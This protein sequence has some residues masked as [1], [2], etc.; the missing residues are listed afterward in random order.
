MARHCHSACRANKQ[1]CNAPAGRGGEGRVSAALPLE[2]P[3]PPRE[4]L[5]VTVVGLYCIREAILLAY[6]VT[7]DGQG[8]DSSGL[9]DAYIAFSNLADSVW[10]AILL[11]IAAGFW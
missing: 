8:G 4:L 1:L 6:A 3:Q 11:S 9:F 2:T 10:F 5:Q 7:T